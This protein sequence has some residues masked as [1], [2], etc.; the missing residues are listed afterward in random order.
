MK[1]EETKLKDS[2]LINLD[3]REDDRGFFAR[4]FCKNEFDKLNL[5]GNVVQ[6]N[7]SL[8]KDSGTLRGIHYQTS[9]KQE[10]KIVRCIKGAIFDVIVDLRPESKTY[11][12]WFGYE[13]NEENRTMMY[14]P[15]D[16]GH[17]F[18]TLKENTEVFYLVTE[19]YSPEHEK[20]IRYNDPAIKIKWPF[21]PIV[22]SP[23]DLLHTDYKP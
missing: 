11:L 17:A 18:L 7:N 4:F 16:F 13:L 5:D 20:G 9:P 8:S 10:T 22:I 1:F 23:K 6:I 15:K 19:F 3:K 21:E 12:D 2:F 14:V